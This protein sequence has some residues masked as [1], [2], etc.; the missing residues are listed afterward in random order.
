M[1][2]A[3]P[4]WDRA[5][6]NE[7]AYFALLAQTPPMDGAALLVNPNVPALLINRAMSL[8][9]SD[10][11]LARDLDRMEEPFLSR[12]IPPSAYLTPASRPP[13]LRRALLARGY[14]SEYRQ[15]VM[16]HDL[17]LGSEGP[18]GGA[19]VP[20][21][22]TV[23]LTTGPAAYQ[24]WC[25]TFL[26]GFEVARDM[27]GVM[28]EMNLR[29]LRQPGVTGLLGLLN[30]RPVATTCLYVAG[31]TAGLYAVSTLPR[32]RRKG[33]AGALVR[34]ALA[35]AKA[36]G[37]TLAILQTATGGDPERLYR[38]LGFKELFVAEVLTRHFWG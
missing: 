12:R 30:G 4:T 27:H 1:V 20:A 18:G 26:G 11:S 34:Q 38:S 24:A 8:R 29:S 32:A 22:L 31:D 21:G 10:D 17:D 25:Q 2:T 36:Q 33:V 23:A 9:L 15:T 14:R 3:V 16:A 6:E 13:G 28:Y 5:E 7:R 37:A 19:P 35:M